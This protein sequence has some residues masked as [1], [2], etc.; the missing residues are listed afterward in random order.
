MSSYLLAFAA[1]ADVC[2]LG[3]AAFLD[4]ALRCRRVQ[5]QRSDADATDQR[6]RGKEG[7]QERGQRTDGT[8]GP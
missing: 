1:P 4:G 7:N 5:G 3:C 2:R 8:T 6:E